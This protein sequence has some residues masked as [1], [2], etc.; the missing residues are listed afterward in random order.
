MGA[1]TDTP[2]RQPPYIVCGG[3]EKRYGMEGHGGEL[4]E[5]TRV[6]LDNRYEASG[7]EIHVGCGGQWLYGCSFALPLDWAL[8]VNGFEEGCD[9]LSAEDYIFGLNLANAGYPL[10][11]DP[12]MWV[13]QDRSPGHENTY[14]RED[15]GV[16]P[17]DKSHAALERFGKGRHTLFTRNLLEERSYYC[18]HRRFRPFD[19]KDFIDWFDG[20]PVDEQYPR[21]RAA[22]RSPARCSDCDHHHVQRM[23]PCYCGCLAEF[24]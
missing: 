21:D 16:S 12:K 10:V 9:G 23:Q 1:H 3:Y 20:E 14:R 22:P 7:G 8:S 6:A 18:E 11:Y 19:A 17:Y 13:I 4:L 5:G 15:K 24:S 2:Y